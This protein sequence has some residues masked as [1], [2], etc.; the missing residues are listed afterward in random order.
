VW[1]G[2]TTK[3]ALLKEFERQMLDFTYKNG[4]FSGKQSGQNDDVI[5][6]LILVLNWS[7]VKSSG[8][9]IAE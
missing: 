7:K 1:Y 3:H 9:I 8:E 5:I 2:R 4:K 6:C